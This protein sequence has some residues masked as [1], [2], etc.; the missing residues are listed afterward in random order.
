MVD[1]RRLLGRE[2]EP[3]QV[4]ALLAPAPNGRAGALLLAGDPGIGKTTL[5]EAATSSLRGVQVIQVDGP[6]CAVDDA[7]LL[8][9]ESLDALTFVARR[10]AAESAALVFAGRDSSQFLHEGSGH[11]LPD[12]DRDRLHADLLAFIDS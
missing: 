10:L 1:G 12:T 4:A 9:A 5:L 8:D 6:V 11:A 3:V 7:H 2:T